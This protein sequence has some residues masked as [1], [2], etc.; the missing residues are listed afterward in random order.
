MSPSPI[1]EKFYNVQ[2]LRKK[3]HT[4]NS[5]E[6]DKNWNDAEE[7]T[8]FKYPWD[9]GQ[10]PHTSFRALHDA[11]WLYFL[12]EAADKNV[13][14][15]VVTNDKWEVVSSDRV[16][17]FFRSNDEMNPYYCLEIDPKG[18][19]L[20]YEAT[21]HRQFNYPWTWPKDQLKI[22]ATEITGGY[23][24]EFAISK[25]AMLDLGLLKGDRIEAGLYRANCVQ[26]ID[27]QAHME[28]ISWVHPDSATP[29]FHIP[30]SFG[31][32]RLIG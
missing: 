24:V 1:S 27:A 19:V 17:I 13:I 9:S 5:W 10:A 6:I 8:D 25:K 2:R 23:R 26:A 32:L 18:R 11:S 4:L 16:E 3:T 14:I 21:F 28:W 12:F 31:T 29:D 22:T 30:S 7:L 15:H 20:D